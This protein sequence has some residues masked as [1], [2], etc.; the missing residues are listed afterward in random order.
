[1]RR[2]SATMVVLFLASA[3]FAKEKPRVTVQVVE[4]ETSER[5]YTRTVAGTAGVSTTNCNTSDN[6]TVSAT[7]RGRTVRG[8]VD[9]NSSSNCT[10]VSRPATPPRTQVRS[11][12]QQNVQAIMADGTQVTLWCQAGLR[13]C[14]SLQPGNYSAEVDGNT[15]WI[16]VRELSGKERKIKFKAVSVDSG[17]ASSKSEGGA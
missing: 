3:A 16:Y 10:T 1:M 9:T 8:V 12:T 7:S 13:K 11:V 14:V 17:A 5:Q 15:V 2:I 6:Q 4:T